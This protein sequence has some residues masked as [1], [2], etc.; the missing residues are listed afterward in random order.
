MVANIEGLEAEN[1]A[2]REALYGKYGV[3]WGLEVVEKCL[4]TAVRAEHGDAP[5]P[6]DHAQAK[7]WHQAQMEAYR[8]VLEMISIDPA[9]A[10]GA[11][12]Y[13]ITMDGRDMGVCSGRTE[14]EALN[15][16]AKDLGY[17]SY[18]DAC[19]RHP[20]REGQVKLLPCE[21]PTPGKTTED[22]AV[23]PA[24]GDSSR[25]KKAQAKATALSE[26]LR[27]LTVFGPEHF[28]LLEQAADAIEHHRGRAIAAGATVSANGGSSRLHGAEA[29][30]TAV[31]KQLRTLRGFGPEHFALLERAADEIEHYRGLALAAEPEGQPFTVIGHN[32]YDR[33]LFVEHVI[34][35][36]G[37]NA[38]AAAAARQ[39]EAEFSV[40]IAGSLTE[41]GSEITLPGE[42]LVPAG[43][44]LTDPDVFGRIPVG[45]LS[46]DLQP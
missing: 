3:A 23:A 36:N 11:V 10:P 28:A 29:K 39:P 44:V 4:A 5:F 9:L 25:V 22:R 18:D 17:S 40:A 16:M 46:D 20:I 43:V 31:S 24:D 41:A 33:K 6:L 32:E 30:E 37:I 8:H 35:A 19:K 12:S 13:R 34:A 27:T 26:Q 21:V 45:A 2:L 15:N 42:G 7:L 38:F 14:N 1:A